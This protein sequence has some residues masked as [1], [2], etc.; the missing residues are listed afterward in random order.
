MSNT[1]RR[2]GVLTSGGDAPGM[3]AAIRGVVRTCAQHDITAVG[4]YRGYNGLIHSDVVE[5]DERSVNGI[6]AKGGTMLYTARCDEFKTAEGQKKGVEACRYL[7][8]DGLITIGGDG[9]FRGAEKLA[10]AGVNTIAIPATIDNDIGCTHY[11]IGFDTAANTA[12]ELTDRLADTMQSHERTSIVEVMGHGAGHLAVYVGMSVGATAIL[13]PE[14]KFDFEEDILERIRDA[15]Y[16]NKNHHLIIVSEGV[17]DTRDLGARIKQE[18]GIDTRITILGH[19]QRGGRP[20]AR[21]RVMATRMGHFAVEALMNGETNQVV[22]YRNS[23]LLL[24]PINEALKMKKSL[25]SYMY[26]VANEVVI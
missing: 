1:M 21:D 16:H 13:I 8:L 23:E 11:S 7:G 3:N 10:N 25:D 6:T 15:K 26:R 12:V 20:T 4:I 5:L 19:I 2:I 24:T 18:L 14:K 17:V 9:T 22:C